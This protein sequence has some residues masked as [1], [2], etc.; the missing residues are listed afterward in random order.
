MPALRDVTAI[1][2]ILETDRAWSAYALGDL[3]PGFFEHCSWFHAPGDAGAL[4]LLYAAFSP[5]VLFAQG[6]PESLAPILDEFATEPRIYLHIRPEILPLLATRYRAVELKAMW[7]MVLDVAAYRAAP[8]AA[9]VRLS[10]AH[11][12]ALEQL[13]SDGDAAGERPDFFY[14]AMLDEGVFYGVWEGGH[15]LAVAGTH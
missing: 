3:A 7:G 11:K 8:N 14:P 6:A 15:L 9:A 5:A 1:R 2:T 4:A 13:Y 10:S 12:S